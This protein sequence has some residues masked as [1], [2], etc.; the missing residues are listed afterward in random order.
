MR[1]FWVVVYPDQTGDLASL[2]VF[3]FFARTK[4]SQ[5]AMSS[6]A[7]AVSTGVID[8]KVVDP[9]NLED[10]EGMGRARRNVY[11]THPVFVPMNIIQ[12]S[13]ACPVALLPDVGLGWLYRYVQALPVFANCGARISRYLDIST[14]FLV[15]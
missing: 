1:F 3:G 10:E 5:Y 6:S 8:V 13:A 12:F 4:D 7:K 9:L 15:P 14:T 11:F 2:N